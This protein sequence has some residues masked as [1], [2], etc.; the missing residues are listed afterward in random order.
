MK[1][2]IKSIDGILDKGGLASRD[3][4]KLFGV[5]VLEEDDFGSLLRN[6][7]W[8]WQ[9]RSWR[10]DGTPKAIFANQFCP[11]LLNNATQPTTI[12]NGT[13]SV[14]ASVV[15]WAAWVKQ[16]DLPTCQGADYVTVS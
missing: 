13:I 12:A 2:S 6:A 4:R 5:E 11:T 8:K 14:P 7:P 10:T 3:L 9:S 15:N 1:A 16:Y